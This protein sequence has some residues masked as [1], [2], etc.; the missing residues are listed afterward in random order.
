MFEKLEKKVYT[1]LSDYL[2]FEVKF[3]LQNTDYSII[4]GGAIRDIIG[5]VEIN[6]ID[7]MC[8]GNSYRMTKQNLEDNGY[9]ESSKLTTKDIAALYSDIHIIYEPATYIKQI[10]NELKIVQLIRPAHVKNF[11]DNGVAHN[12]SLNTQLLN[13]NYALENVDI[14]IC[15]VGY[16]TKKGLFEIVDGSIFYILNKCF[17][18]N[19]N[20]A[21]YHKNR[22]YIRIE[23]M[24]NKGYLCL[25]GTGGHLNFKER[26]R[27]F[28]EIEFKK[29]RFYKLNNILT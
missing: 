24:K 13:F 6:D 8:F 25:S 19:N 15:G 10:N 21:M 2:G 28:K 23:K 12:N 5:N 7:I 22:I 27:I 9:F 4:F 1:K 18:V 20:A 14:N 11:G 17:T 3:L 26:E 16:S 29:E